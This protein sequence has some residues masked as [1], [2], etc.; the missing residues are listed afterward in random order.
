MLLARHLGA[1]PSRSQLRHAARL[2]EADD[3]LSE[4]FRASAEDLSG[5]V[6]RGVSDATDAAGAAG[7]G[8]GLLDLLVELGRDDGEAP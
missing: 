6:W 7:C 5:A 2:V 4:V 1:A 8:F 3:E